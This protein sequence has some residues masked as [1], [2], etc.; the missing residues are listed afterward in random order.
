MRVRPQDR[1]AS[2]LAVPC[3]QSMKMVSAFS[4]VRRAASPEET[5]LGF[6][7]RICSPAARRWRSLAPIIV[8]LRSLLGFFLRSSGLVESGFGRAGALRR[9]EPTGEFDIGGLVAHPLVG[10]ITSSSI[11]VR[12][13]R[14]Q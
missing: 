11:T 3:S 5:W 14:V 13:G 4:S 8:Y 6:I 10:T 7:I 1:A 12:D 9:A 2:K